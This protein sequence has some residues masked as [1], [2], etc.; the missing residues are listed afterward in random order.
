MKK[1]CLIIS[2]L[3]TAIS[4]FAQNVPVPL[5]STRLYDFLDELMTDGIIIEQQT[6]VRPYSRSQVANMLEQAQ[7]ADSLLN[8]NLTF[9]ISFSI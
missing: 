6:A 1:I 7:V 9:V 2:V 5:T 8:V 3:S 4:V